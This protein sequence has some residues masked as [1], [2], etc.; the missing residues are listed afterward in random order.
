MVDDFASAV[1]RCVGRPR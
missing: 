1:L